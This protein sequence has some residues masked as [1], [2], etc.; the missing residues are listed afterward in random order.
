[1]IGYM[2]TCL[3]QEGEQV[4]IKTFASS[5]IE[6]VDN[7]VGFDN[8]KKITNLTNSDG[9]SWKI[10][11]NLNKLRKLRANLDETLLDRQINEI[12]S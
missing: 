8:L 12:K 7:F 3:D 1:M 6:A 11:A 5:P 10:K 2:A 9:D 4:K